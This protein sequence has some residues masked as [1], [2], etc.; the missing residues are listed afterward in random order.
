MPLVK[1]D[2]LVKKKYHGTFIWL[3]KKSDLFY[4]EAITGQ[5]PAMHRITAA[6][7]TR[8]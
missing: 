3:V 2:N 6:P 7:G 1:D 4:R 5:K 8:R